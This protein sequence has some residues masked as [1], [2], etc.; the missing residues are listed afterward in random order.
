MSEH[1]KHF[2][3]GFSFFAGSMI[4]AISL[5]IL[6]WPKKV[7]PPQPVSFG[8]GTQIVEDKPTDKPVD[9]IKP[10]SPEL[11]AKVASFK[12]ELASKE[13]KT[14]EQKGEEVM[15]AINLYNQVSA[16]TGKP[17]VIKMD[18]NTSFAQAILNSLK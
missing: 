13:V 5:L 9:T 1:N 14:E 16:E 12:V 10:L 6:V 2:W 3:I 11:S 8:G 7:T 4:L 18:E 15:T 17:L